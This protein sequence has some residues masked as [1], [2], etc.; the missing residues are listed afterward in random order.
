MVYW[1][2]SKGTVGPLTNKGLLSTEALPSLFNK[3][4]FPFGIVAGMPL[5]VALKV[6]VPVGTPFPEVPCTSA[7]MNT[8]LP[9]GR[10]VKGTV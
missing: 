1:P 4:E 8:G 3:A 6:T 7:R 5:T 9:K 2:A 10:V